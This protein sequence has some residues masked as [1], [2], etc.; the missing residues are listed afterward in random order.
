MLR[1]GCVAPKLG[2][3][4]LQIGYRIEPPINFAGTFVGT[5]VL[6]FVLSSIYAG[7]FIE[8]GSGLGTI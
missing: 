7:D 1:S 4:V 8:R 2:S 6:R 3:Q 5:L